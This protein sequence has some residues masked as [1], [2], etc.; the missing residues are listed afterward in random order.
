LR[1]N[2]NTLLRFLLTFL[3]LSSLIPTTAKAHDGPPFALV[4]DQKAGPY[5]VSVWTDPDV[6]TGT[7]FVIVNTPQGAS[8]P[9]DLKVQVAVQ[10]ASG[11]LAEVSYP[12]ERENLRDQLQYKALVQF[13]AQELWRVRVSI[14]SA[15]GSGEIAATVEPTPIGLGRWDLLIYLAPFLMIGVLWV[16]VVVRKRNKN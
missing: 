11:R 4:V 9:A 14:N 1:H 12:A 5:V 10:P 6:G 13:D 8:V 3:V 7:F 15:M 16:I 2:K